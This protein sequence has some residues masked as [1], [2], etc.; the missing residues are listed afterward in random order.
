MSRTLKNFY[1]DFV[2]P[3]YHMYWNSERLGIRI[4]LDVRQN[5]IDKYKAIQSEESTNL[6]KLVGHELNVESPVKVY[7]VLYDE[8]KIPR[9]T[10]TK[11]DTLK[12]LVNNFVPNE[13][14]KVIIKAILRMR[15]VNKFVS[16]YLKAKLDENGRIRTQVKV[17]GTTTG[18]TSTAKLKSPISIEPIGM[19]LQTLTKHGD[20]GAEIRNMFVPDPGMV[21]VEADQSQAEARV[22]SLLAEDYEFLALFDKVDTHKLTATYITG[23]AME[24]ISKD[25]RQL[26]KKGRHSANYDVGSKRLSLFA[27][28]SVAVATRT[29]NII[30]KKSPNIRDVFH[31]DV[32]D[33]LQ[34]DKMILMTPFGRYRQFYEQW[35]DNLFKDGYAHI[36]QS[37]VS[38]QTKLALLNIIDRASYFQLLLESH[39]GFLGQVPEDKVEEALPIIQEELEK[40]IDFSIG[41]LKRKSLVI[42]CEIAISDVSWG[43]MKGVKL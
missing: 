40:P 42:P 32:R 5:L 18:R 29:L 39:D 27:E 22:S 35:G 13:D 37:T 33:H 6:T 24:S 12:N 3:L 26:G 8:L 43:A 7:E 17:H 19:A 1:E 31:K 11:E 25:E 15:K 28:V 34:R 2:M 14:K 36:P 30:H 20:V 23:K 41:S 38:D 9:R 4:D 16:T 21:F 10:N